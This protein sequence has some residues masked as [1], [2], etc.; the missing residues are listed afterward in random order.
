MTV[1][2]LENK[3]EREQLIDKAMSTEL[4]LAEIDTQRM[5]EEIE[6]LLGLTDQL[7]QHPTRSSGRREKWSER[8]M[9]SLQNEPIGI[10]LGVDGRIVQSCLHESANLY[11]I[12]AYRS[13]SWTNNYEPALQYCLFGNDGDEFVPFTSTRGHHIPKRIDIHPLSSQQK[14]LS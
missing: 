13:Q 4:E 7:A 11:Q 9:Q 1:L 2:E 10:L 12:V 3:L 14:Q 8:L 5:Q 6:L